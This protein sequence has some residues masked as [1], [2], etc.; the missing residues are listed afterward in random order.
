MYGE[1]EVSSS[2]SEVSKIDDL[3]IG[4]IIEDPKTGLGTMVHRISDGK[5]LAVRFEEI[6]FKDFMNNQ[7]K[8]RKRL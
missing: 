6:E 7:W 3:K 2:Y 8:L 5:I 1:E 4:D